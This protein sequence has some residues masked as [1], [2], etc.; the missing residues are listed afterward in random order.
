M[1]DYFSPYTLSK[2]CTTSLIKKKEK[3]SH[4]NLIVAVFQSN[5]AAEHK[6]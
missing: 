3:L 1:N 5:R 6:I 4:D 2:M